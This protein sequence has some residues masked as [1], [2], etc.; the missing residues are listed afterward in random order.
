MQVLFYS[1]QFG[2]YALG[3]LMYEYNCAT[4][5]PTVSGF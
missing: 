1:A 4:F 3:L 5:R 2:S